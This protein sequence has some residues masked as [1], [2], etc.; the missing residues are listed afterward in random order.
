MKKIILSAMLSSVLLINANAQELKET[1]SE[2]LETNPIVLERLKNY[3]MKKSNVEIAKA[4]YYPRLDLNLG[5]GV[6]KSDYY[7]TDTHTTTR[8]DTLTV[9]QNSLKYTQN[10]FKGFDTQYQISSEEMGKLASA[11]SY[12]EKANDTSFEMVNVYLQV[13]KQTEL[14]QTAQENIDINEDILKKVEKLYKNGLTTLSEVNKIKSSLSNAE[15]NYVVSKNS[16]ADVNY[17]MLKVLG[18]VLDTQNM[19]RPMIT[20]AIPASQEEAIAFA[21]KN[22]PSLI[23]SEYNIKLA[24]ATYKGSKS[25]YYPS[26]D[27]EI[28]QTMNKNMNGIESEDKPLKAMLYLSYNIFN[29]FSDEQTIER[30]ALAIQQEMEVLN[31]LKRE[32]LEGLNLSWIANE[33]LSEQNDFLISYRDYSEKTL[34]LYKKEYDLGRRSLL[35]L[36]SAQ[37]D[38]IGAKSKIIETEY[39]IL[40]A[41]YRIFD[42]M[43]TLV[44]SVLGSEDV[45]FTKVELQEIEEKRAEVTQ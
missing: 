30:S 10:I 21:M 42:A 8:D 3:N 41:K 45:V 14:L 44:P 17:N 35:D 37:N 22:N 13:M 39:S 2:V 11:Y 16:L 9:Y 23:V 33:M 28:S 15:S 38:F 43:G 6:E 25:N 7:D 34:T 5:V 19:Q 24:K 40:F 20:M 12:V 4:G 31:K 36:L 32:V 27:L 26:V 29:G 1:V 18:R